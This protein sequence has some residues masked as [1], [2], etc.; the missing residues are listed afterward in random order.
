MISH[1]IWAFG[2]YYGCTDFDKEDGGFRRNIFNYF[3]VFHENSKKF[4][5]KLV[6]YAKTERVSVIRVLSSKAIQ[7][8]FYDLPLF[9]GVRGST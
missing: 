7:P 4:I 1:A 3:M 9:C 2:L 5:K 8:T 6:I